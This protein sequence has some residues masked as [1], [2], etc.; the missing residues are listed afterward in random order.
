MPEISLL[1]DFLNDCNWMTQEIPGQNKKR[2]FIL[3]I[4]K[5]TVLLPSNKLYS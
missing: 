2:I 4:I 1:L 3:H 5:K